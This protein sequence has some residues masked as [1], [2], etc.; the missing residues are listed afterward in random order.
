MKKLGLLGALLALAGMCSVAIGQ[1]IGYVASAGNQNSPSYAFRDN[2]GLPVS[3]G[4]YFTGA[5]IAF[6]VNGARVLEIGPAGLV[7]GMVNVTRAINFEIGDPAGSALTAGATT[8][9]YKV[10]PYTCNLSGWNLMVD[11][12]T[13]TV[14]FWKKAAGTAKPASGDSIN[15]NGVAIATGTVI[16]STDMSDFTTV[17]IN[18]GDILAMNV[19]TTATAKYV[20]ATLQCTP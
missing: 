11:A 18:A 19:S 5:N 4:M 3:T 6:A 7:A 1:Q 9:R 8:T 12:G 10:L 16:E 13:M 14:K 17:A 15:T 20:S 2:T